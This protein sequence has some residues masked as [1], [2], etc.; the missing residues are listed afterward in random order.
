MN[1]L[2]ISPSP[3]IPHIGGVERVTDILSRELQRKGHGVFF[4]SYM[5]E[6]FLEYKKFSAPQYYI[7]LKKGTEDTKKTSIIEIVKRHNISCVI[8]Q[9]CN[10]QVS[11]IVGY[12]PEQLRKKVVFV[13]HIVPFYS[14][15]ITRH[16]I[17]QTPTH[18]T[19]Q[20]VFKMASVLF[21]CIYRYW[22]SN[23]NKKNF[24]AI[25]PLANKVCF[26]SNKFYN[27]VIKHIPNAPLEK[28]TYIPNPNTYKEQ[29]DVPSYNE[30]ENAVLW[31]GRVENTQKNIIGF[32]NMWKFFS[33]KHQNWKAYV[34]GDGH[35]LD[36]CKKYV[37][38][39]Q[40]KGIYF[41]GVQSCVAQ[42][43]KKCKFYCMTS[44]SES[45]GMVITEAMTFGCVPIAMD[46]YATLRDIIDDG[47]NG[48]ICKP[49]AV[50]MANK[51]NNVADNYG[52]WTELSHNARHKVKSYDISVIASQWEQLLNDL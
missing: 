29:V 17:W 23:D 28:F 39:K 21:P 41:E 11:E 50:E 15:Y 46:N 13:Y 43:Y 35:D 5:D 22:F 19:R 12:L 16:R 37:T 24:N 49:T 1:I 47:V 2:F 4:L 9:S 48:L 45:W 14:D 40:I 42:Y 36:Y 20:L 6:C 7:S 27:N 26:I 34:V 51:L 33:Q 30:R 10:E 25:F 38:K 32:L 18:N 52:K 31:V 3:I 8:C 44:Y